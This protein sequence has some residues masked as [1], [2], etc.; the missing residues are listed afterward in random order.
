MLA[1]GV[2]IFCLSY[3]SV[4]LM[5]EQEQARTHTAI[6]F[7]LQSLA[8]SPPVPDLAVEPI[9]IEDPK[10]VWVYQESIPKE[11]LVFVSYSGKG[12]QPCI[13]MKR[14]VFSRDDVMGALHEYDTCVEWDTGK[15]RKVRS[16]PTY[17]VYLDGK[18][19]ATRRGQC[20]ASTMVAWLTFYARR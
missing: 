6:Q 12:C 13:I 8:G 18:L 10:T 14:E 19:K 3:F 2:V 20:K 4:N 17:S 7:S 9:V 15:R 1:S 16:I 11:G 5:T